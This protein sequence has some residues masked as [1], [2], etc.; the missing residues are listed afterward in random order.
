MTVHAASYIF[1]PHAVYDACMHVCMLSAYSFCV[2]FSFTV[3]ECPEL[4]F[5]PNGVITYDPDMIA[6]Y[7]VNTVATHTCIE[8]FVLIA[9]SE[10]RVCLLGG[11]WSGVTCVCQRT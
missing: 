11:R 5:I 1:S 2:H 3:V 9:G 7:D 8:S 10:T 6:P 4:P